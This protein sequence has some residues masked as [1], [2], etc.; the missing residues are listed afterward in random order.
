MGAENIINIT[1]NKRT[2]ERVFLHVR[3]FD[4]SCDIFWLNFLKIRLFL[5]ADNQDTNA[6]DYQFYKIGL[7]FFNGR[8]TI[9]QD[10]DWLYKV[11]AQEL[12]DLM[13][14]LCNF[15]RNIEGT[16]LRIS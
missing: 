7:D 1:Y 8:L 5:Y 13:G 6:I 12:K 9:L 4:L 2:R 16:N 11:G 15:G 14:I 3:W 10:M